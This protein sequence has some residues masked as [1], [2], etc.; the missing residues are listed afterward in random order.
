TRR[1][2]IAAVRLEPWERGVVL[3]HE[4]TY[5]RAKADRL[6]LLEATQT[7]ISPILVFFQRGARSA[8]G[9]AEAAPSAE[10]DAVL[11][12]WAFVASRT[13]DASGTDSEGVRHRLWVLAD[14][15]FVEALHG[16]FVDRPLFI[17][18]GHHR[19]ETALN[20]LEQRR[21]R[22]GGDLAADDP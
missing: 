16:Y 3:P 15:P 4:R 1:E 7:N 12:A 14:A 21:Q 13:P 17:A 11:A 22:V 20:F 6:R 19:Y 2:L 10:P 18:D 9:T 8:S 5:P